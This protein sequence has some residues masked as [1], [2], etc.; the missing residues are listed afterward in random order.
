MLLRKMKHFASVVFF[1]RSDQYMRSLNNCRLELEMKYDF[2]QFLRP[3]VN[4][5]ISLI[6]SKD[7]IENQHGLFT[8]SKISLD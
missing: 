2:V 1:T 4:S 6:F 5:R 7:S 3:M 8:L